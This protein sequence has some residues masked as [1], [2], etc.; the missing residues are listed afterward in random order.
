MTLTLRALLDE[1]RLRMHEAVAWAAEI[2]AEMAELYREGQAHGAVLAENVLIDGGNAHL[3]PAI[4]PH[5][6]GDLPEFAALLRQMLDRV[7]MNTDA[8]RVQGEILE[9]IAATNENAASNIGINK[10]AAA[11]RLLRFTRRREAP[12]AQETIVPVPPR[13]F[14]LKTI[15]VSALLASAATVAVIGCMLVLKFLR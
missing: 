13:R 11:L 5:A 9:R 15:H 1:R 14:V 12:A 6:S 7:E 8:E 2:S 10:V 3:T 4:N